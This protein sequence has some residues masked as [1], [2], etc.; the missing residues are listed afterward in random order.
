MQI[1]ASRIVQAQEQVGIARAHQFPNVGAGPGFTASAS[2]VLV[3]LTSSCKAL[4]SW[5]PISGAGTAAPRKRLAPTNSPPN[6]TAREVLGTVVANVA[7]AYF[8]MREL[9]S[10]LDLASGHWPR[11]RNRCS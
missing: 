6:G 3:Q 1:A 10:E 8:Q 4:F 5:N 9:D 7:M 11:G 2:R